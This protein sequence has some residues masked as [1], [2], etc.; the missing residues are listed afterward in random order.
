MRQIVFVWGYQL[1]ENNLCG[2]HKHQHSSTAGLK[3]S[4]NRVLSFENK[5]NFYEKMELTHIKK[6]KTNVKLRIF[7]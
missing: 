6:D 7:M 1:G 4:L 3:K 2:P 5:S